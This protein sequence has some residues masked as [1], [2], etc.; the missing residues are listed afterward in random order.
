[1]ELVISIVKI[2][3]LIK[4]NILKLIKI[5]FGILFMFLFLGLLWKGLFFISSDQALINTQI[6]N[7]RSPNIGKVDFLKKIEPGTIL[8]KD[9]KI[10]RINDFRDVL[11]QVPKSNLKSIDINM[12]FTG[13]VW[14]VLAKN[15]EFVQRED[16]IIQVISPENIWVDA[17]FREQRWNELKIGRRVKVKL[18]D[19]NKSWDGKIIFVRAGVNRVNGELDPVQ[20]DS[21][22][23]FPPS[24]NI[25]RLVDAR[26]EVQWDDY[27]LPKNFF[28]IGRS[29]VVTLE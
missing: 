5:S 1:M 21:D 27:F 20:L 26:I 14:S 9:E 3:L 18:L 10:I 19:S 17:F 11:S 22:F 23:V 4:E 24:V 29:V 6:T 16:K 13:V 12:P 8:K 28:G 7:L 15:E 25:K 2:I